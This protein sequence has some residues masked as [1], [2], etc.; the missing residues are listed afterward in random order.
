MSG[1]APLSDAPE[2]T[3]DPDPEE[4]PGGPADVVERDRDDLPLVTPDQ[5]RSAQVEDHQV[6]DG[7]EDPE[8][9]DE[10]EKDVDPAED[11]PV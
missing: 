10:G 9:L 4:G 5:P 2:P 3:T 7:L 8:E 1:D 11:K 6:P